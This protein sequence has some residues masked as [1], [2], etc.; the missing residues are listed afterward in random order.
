[1]ES[2][3]FSKIHLENRIENNIENYLINSIIWDL[4]NW[5]CN[6]LFSISGYSKGVQVQT[7]YGS[8]RLW[9]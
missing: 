8:I 4:F 5:V 2:I 3:R 6:C 1:M 9:G 7:N